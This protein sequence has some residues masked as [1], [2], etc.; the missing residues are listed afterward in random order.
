MARTRV[1]KRWLVRMDHEI[2][3][4][5]DF[6]DCL[7]L[8]A[9]A[10]YM[11]SLFFLASGPGPEGLYP[12]AELAA[13]YGPA[14]GAVA[15]QLVVFGIWKDLGLGY[16]VLPYSG[17]RVIP[18]ARAPIPPEVREFV[19]ARDGHAC[20]ECSTAEDLTLDHIYPW[21]LGGSDEPGNLRAL[22]RPCNCRKG[23]RV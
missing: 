9:R 16:N 1:P 14:A 5:I 4:D 19:Y 21:S 18:E 23:A 11:D 15:T 8:A 6:H 13:G 3:R 10:A 7:D 12:H 22:C 2:T 20:C 17:W